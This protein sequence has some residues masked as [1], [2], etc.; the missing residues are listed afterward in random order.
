[1]ADTGLV[2]DSE[3]ITPFRLHYEHCR[4]LDIKGQLRACTSYLENPEI[5]MSEFLEAYHLVEREW[6]P[7]FRFKPDEAES[8]PELVLERFYRSLEICV[9]EEQ[10][11]VGRV[12]CAS[13]AVSPL[14]SEE[15]P[16]VDRRGL[17]Y[18]AL[19][20]GDSPAVVLGVTEAPEERTPFVLLLRLLNCFAELAPPFQ[21]I[22]LAGELIEA[23]LGPETRFDLQFVVGHEA[24][25]GSQALHQ[26][27]R[28]LADVFKT[29][30]EREDQ[31]EGTLGSIECL[32]SGS[33][34]ES[35]DQTELERLWAV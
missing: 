20:E 25:A 19:R 4:S 11:G 3:L 24:T 13:G 12:M 18:V 34:D 7:D 27:S 21:I 2:S 33:V 23:R 26:F 28:D 1:M 8:S 9:R 30:I 6:D 16:A 29:G 5:L 32:S 35:S 15:H 10:Q 31:F 14:R 22:R 17:D